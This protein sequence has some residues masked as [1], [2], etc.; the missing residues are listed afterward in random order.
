MIFYQFSAGLKV[1]FN[2]EFL[3]LLKLNIHQR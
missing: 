2:K 3:C 1:F